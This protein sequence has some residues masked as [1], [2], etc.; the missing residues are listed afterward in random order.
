LQTVVE[1]YLN[2]IPAEKFT[3]NKSRGYTYK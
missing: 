2:Y 1:Q 3:N